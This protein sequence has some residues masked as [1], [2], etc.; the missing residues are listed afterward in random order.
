[1]KEYKLL[2]TCDDCDDNEKVLGM[3]ILLSKSLED[4]EKE[5]IEFLTKLKPGISRPV[6]MIEYYNSLAFDKF[7]KINIISMEKKI[8]DCDFNKYLFQYTKQKKIE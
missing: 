5:A 3:H 6:S 2:I 1:M 4:A 8:Y 7:K